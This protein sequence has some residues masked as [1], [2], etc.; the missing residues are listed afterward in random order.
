MKNET[1]IIVQ[2]DIHLTWIHS[3]NKLT[4]HTIY[5]HFYTPKQFEILYKWFDTN[6]LIWYTPPP[7]LT[8]TVIVRD[9][10]VMIIKLILDM[11]YG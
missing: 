6:S 4:N 10:R 9:P 3:E 2:Y 7:F 5:E 11:I 8:I 1:E